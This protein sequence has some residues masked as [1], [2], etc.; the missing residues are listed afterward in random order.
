MYLEAG[1]KVTKIHA[2][3]TFEQKR[4]KKKF[5]LM[6]QKSRQES[7]N[8][9]EKDFYK[10]MNNSNFVTTDL[11]KQDIEKKYNNKL[12]KLD[13]EDKFYVIKLN[14][15]NYQRLSDLEAAENFEKKEKKKKV[16]LNLVNFSERKSE[17]LRN[18][19][20]EALIDFDEECSSSIKSLAIKQ[21]DKVNLTTR[22]LNGKMLMFSKVSIKSFVYDLIDV[23]MFPNEEIKKIYAEFKVDRCYLYQNLTD[24]DSTSIFFVFICDL[25]CSIDERKSRDI[26]S[27]VMIKSKIFERLDLSDDFWDQFGVQNKKLKKQGGLFEIESINKANVITIALNPK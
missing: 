6:N 21:S 12:I 14:T 10:L 27:K 7:K 24:T 15:I 22:H 17:A 18:Q 11:I 26:I 20:V 25:K 8:N 2:H 4:F 16:R 19:K 23:F 5:I 13:K 1:W 9:I 3:L